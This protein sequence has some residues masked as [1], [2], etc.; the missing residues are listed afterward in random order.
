MYETNIKQHHVGKNYVLAS[1]YN[2]R[3]FDFYPM[4]QHQLR[5]TRTAH[6]YTLGLPG[7]HVEQLWIV[8]HGYAQMASDFLSAFQVLNLDRC[9]VVAPEGTNYFYQ[10]GF[11]GPVVANWMTKYERLSA[12]EDN[13]LFL[14]TLYTECTAQVGPDTRIVLLG[15]SQGTATVCRWVMAERPLFN[16][17]LLWAGMPPEDLDYSGAKD[18]LSDKNLYLLYGSHDP[19]LTPDRLTEVQELENRHGIDFQE[20]P[21][22]GGHEIDPQTLSDFLVKFD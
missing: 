16:D 15:F 10:K 14:Q 11:S 5:T 20:T 18:Y 13:N 22:E 3:K 1:K 17:L 8:C 9:W 19:L 2:S 6:Y 21:F 12:I 7:P 4:N